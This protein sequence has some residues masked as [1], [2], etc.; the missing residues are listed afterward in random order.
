[1]PASR[2]MDELRKQA[3]DLI[4]DRLRT[5][6]VA[7]VA[8]DLDISRQAVYDIKRG[9]Y[10]PS[11]ALVQKACEVW[12][13][14]F[15]FR[16]ILIDSTSFTAKEVGSAMSGASPGDL[17]ESLQQLDYRNFEVIQT[18]RMG[19]ALEITLRLTLPAQK[20]AKG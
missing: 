14:R 18:K 4:V 6:T 20:T 17:L 1:M 5:T 2:P 13:V 12:K 16:G 3:A 11:L 9:K 7:D 15:A 19:Q 10:C 8:T